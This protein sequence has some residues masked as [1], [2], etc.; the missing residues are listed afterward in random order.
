MVEWSGRILSPALHCPWRSGGKMRDQGTISPSLSSLYQ[1]HAPALVHPRWVGRCV[2]VVYGWE[3]LL[4]KTFQPKTAVIGHQ[5]WLQGW[6]RWWTPAVSFYATLTLYLRCRNIAAN[7]QQPGIFAFVP[8][9]N[10]RVGWVAFL[11]TVGDDWGD[12]YR[13]LL[14]DM[15]SCDGMLSNC[16]SL[17]WNVS[18]LT[19]MEWRKETYRWTSQFLVLLM[20]MSNNVT[21][22]EFQMNLW[23]ENILRMPLIGF[24][25]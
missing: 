6:T 22:I 23:L 16:W 10:G 3:M 17:E 7:I 2:N 1:D 11:V 8:G 15:A 13:L 20:K 25:L 14:D 9:D 12:V 21:G 4:N 5:S 18:V 19:L 24:E